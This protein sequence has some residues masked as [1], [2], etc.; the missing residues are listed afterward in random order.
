M[1]DILRSNLQGVSGFG[2]LKM[3]SEAANDLIFGLRDL[4][5]LCWHVFLACKCFHELIQR[6]KRR[7]H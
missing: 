6:R 5:Y 2:G 7:N 1:E 4:N 3:T